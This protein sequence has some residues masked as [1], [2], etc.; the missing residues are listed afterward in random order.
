MNKKLLGEKIKRL[1]TARGLTQAEL[2]GASITRNML[3]NIENG[4]ALPSLDTLDYIANNLS[5]SSSYLISDDNDYVFFEKKA[6]ISRIY[7]AYSAKNYPA[8]IN[9]I[10]S[11]DENGIDNELSYLLAS[12]YLF[13]G[14]RH[15]NHGSLVKA[16]EA[17]E[18]SEKYSN[19]TVIET[20]HLKAQIQMYKS[21][22]KNVQSPLLEFD[23][24]K[25]SESLIESVDFEF[26]KY[27]TQDFAYSFENAVYSLHLEAKKLMQ[28]RNYHEAIKRLLNA[29]EFSKKEDF[30]SFVIF[31]I[32]TDLEY[33]YKQ[34]YNFEKAYLYSTKRIT[35]LES[36]KS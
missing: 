7:R 13:L 26:Y 23:A 24:R 29:S 1:R 16:M 31:C 35:L 19:K 34:L 5:V 33:C 27:L 32:Y 20:E 21:I 36:F 11:I 22:A 4:K 12:S 28:E 3:S 18:N 15:I 8:C 25:Y 17:L 2:A 14:K 9:L 10:K 6:L 30:N